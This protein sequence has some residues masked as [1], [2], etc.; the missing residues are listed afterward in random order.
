MLHSLKRALPAG[1][2]WL[3]IDHFAIHWRQ[4]RSCSVDVAEFEQALKD[5]ITARTENDPA[6]EMQCLRTAAQ[7][8]ED[9]LLPGLYDDWISPLRDEFR[10]KVCAALERL[11]T[12]LEEQSEYAA[13]I[14]YAERLLVLDALSEPYHQLLIRLHAANHDRASALRA[15]HQ[16][17]RAL[18]R[19]M[20]VE[21]DAAT[22][23]LF[24]RILKGNTGSDEATPLSDRLPAAKAMSHVPKLQAMVGRTAEW[25]ELTRAWRDAA[26]EGL[27]AAIISGE[28]GIGKSR[29]AEELYL[30]CV[31][32][33]HACARSRCYAGGGQVA[34][35]PVAEW[36]RS[37]AVRAGWSTL[38]PYRLASLA[39][40]VP[41]I[42]EQFS[43]TD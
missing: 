20:G 18:R 8:Y 30:T 5:A 11:A 15:Y 33:G 34:Y 38:G 16:C 31:R 23:E 35:A 13:A 2:D 39:R 22:K 19:E 40:L 25:G 27:R 32:Q 43:E 14:P 4:H 29:L 9:D 12:M 42:S 3:V 28:P 36:L 1:C 7:L 6:R 10:K 21:P 26:Q 41:E 37:D 24:E 17:M